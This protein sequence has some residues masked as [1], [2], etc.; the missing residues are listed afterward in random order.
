MRVNM[1]FNCV[2]SN[3]TF[4]ITINFWIDVNILDRF[5]YFQLNLSSQCKYELKYFPPFSLLLLPN[6][7]LFSYVQ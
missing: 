7:V 3:L 2:L 4:K 5:V 1:Y 6:P